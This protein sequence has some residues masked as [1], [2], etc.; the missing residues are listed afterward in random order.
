[1]KWFQ[2]RP[3]LILFLVAPIIGE[4][5]SGSSPL[6][7]F[8]NP[9]TFLTL[10]MLYGSGAVIAR[11]LIVRWRKSWPSLLLLGFAYGIY[12]E[13]L[14]V[15]SFFDPAWMDLGPLG[16]YGRAAGVN[17]VWTY[18]LT[19]FHALVSI[20]ASIVFV[21]VLYPADRAVPWVT[22]RK[23]WL[24]LWGMLLLMLPI[25]KF[26]TPYDAPDLWIAL[27][28]LA[29]LALMG[30]ARVVPAPPGRARETVPLPRRFFWLA[31]LGT[32][33]H[34]VAIYYGAENDAYPFEI[35]LL[36]A[37]FLDASILWLALRW[38]GNFAAWDDRHRLAFLSGVL[39]FFLVLAPLTIG[40]Q[41]PVLYISNPLFL[42]LLYLVY[43]RV[44]P[45]VLV[46]MLAS[47]RGD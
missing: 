14:V 41:Y 45:R 5:F 25:G 1:M 10:A 35:A 42:L 6:N 43:R 11:E 39:A 12:E 2:S 37:V 20:A 31:F 46:G 30:L 34:H 32:L 44:K 15:R 22:G 47:T 24:A 28:W 16:V 29:I 33:G 27:S 13:G 38:S 17:W 3:A 4:L 21:E 19:V 18:H 9:L 8:I 23:W 7:E 40:A 26:L 36:L